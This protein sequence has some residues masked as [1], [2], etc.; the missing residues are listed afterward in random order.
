MIRN[1]V[2][3]ACKFGF[4]SVWVLL[5]LFISLGIRLKRLQPQRVWTILRITMSP[6]AFKNFVQKN[7]GYY[8]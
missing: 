8:S 3:F 1:R 7:G 2:H 6:N 4:P 5:G